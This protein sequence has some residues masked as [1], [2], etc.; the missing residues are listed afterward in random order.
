MHQETKLD[1]LLLARFLCYE[2]DGDRL[3]PRLQHLFGDTLAVNDEAGLRELLKAAVGLADDEPDEHNHRPIRAARHLLKMERYPRNTQGNRK[4]SGT[5]WTV[6]KFI[7]WADKEDILSTFFDPT[8]I[9]TQRRAIAACAGG[10]GLDANVLQ[11]KGKG[12]ALIHRFAEAVFVTL[13]RLHQNEQ[14]FEPFRIK[15]VQ[16]EAVEPPE[17]H[18]VDEGED[19]EDRPDVGPEDPE[20]SPEAEPEENARDKVHYDSLLGLLLSRHAK[21]LVQL[22]R[23]LPLVVLAIMAF[24]FARTPFPEDRNDQ[25][26]AG[27]G[28]RQSFPVEAALIGRNLTTGADGDYFDVGVGEVAEYT[29]SLRN[30]GKTPVRG[31]HLSVRID[32]RDD[33]VSPAWYGESPFEIRVDLVDSRDWIDGNPAKLVQQV[34]PLWEEVDYPYGDRCFENSKPEIVSISEETAEIPGR[35]SGTIPVSD[36]PDPLVT[37][38]ALSQVGFGL[39]DWNKDLRIVKIRVAV[40]SGVE[41]TPS[42]LAR[43]GE[44]LTVRNARGETGPVVSARAGEELL[45]TTEL[46]DSSCSAR[47]DG[48]NPL[49]RLSVAG[50]TKTGSSR[51]SAQITD[52]GG[53]HVGKPIE[54]DEAFVN[55]A[56]GRQH[57]LSAVPGSTEVLGLEQGD[58]NAP[59]KLDR[60]PDGILQAGITIGPIFGYVPRDQCDG[61]GSVR[62]VRFRV[63]VE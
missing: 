22:A 59:T 38:E 56:D 61:D 3:I 9:L 49:L 52:Q 16:P 19:P 11:P 41:A 17:E 46:A 43:G 13:D 54:I 53:A 14:A 40:R 5:E 26:E 51:L 12:T 31:G 10:Y 63:R 4:I 28:R 15:P 39:S 62:W 58:C 23:A 60:L 29:L 32:R 8:S 6:D 50:D 2:L 55:Y 1:R 42:T 36:L 30:I 37:K 34:L 25:D 24:L 45:V 20:E 44:V 27:A 35:D 7:L 33:Y 47:T 21:G 57:R 48:V 18:P